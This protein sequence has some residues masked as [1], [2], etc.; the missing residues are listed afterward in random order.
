MEISREVYE[1][2]HNRIQYLDVSSI[3]KTDLFLLFEKE[4]TEKVG[5]DSVG[6][7]AEE[8]HSVSRIDGWFL[9]TQVLPYYKNESHV[10]FVM[11]RV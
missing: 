9:Q 11:K 3:K 8:I 6:W 2:Y 10:W 7:P 4:I 5:T 1:W